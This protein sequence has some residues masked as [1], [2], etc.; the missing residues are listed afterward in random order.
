MKDLN[1]YLDHL[2]GLAGQCSK[3][4]RKLMTLG[5]EVDKASTSSLRGAAGF[6]VGGVSAAVGCTVF[7][8][9]LALGGFVLAATS[10]LGYVSGHLSLRGAARHEQEEASSSWIELRAFRDADIR[11]LA[12]QAQVAR[13]A[14]APNLQLEQHIGFLQTAGFDQLRDFYRGPR[15]PAGGVA[16]LPPPVQQARLPHIPTPKLTHKPEGQNDID[17]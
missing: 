11:R 17:G 13:R 3:T 9:P 6:L 16:A 1:Y 4:L 8:A 2:E 7:H 14:S 5:R 10:T 12:P 15:Q